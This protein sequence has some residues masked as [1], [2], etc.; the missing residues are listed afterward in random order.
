MVV[1]FPAPFGPRKP[2]TCPV[3]TSRS[4]PSRATVDPKDL[5]RPDTEMAVLMRTTVHRFQKNVNV[6]KSPYDGPRD[7]PPA[8]PG[9]PLG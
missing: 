1:D 3:C 9:A 4:R 6:L 5:R 8:N 7:D 2:C